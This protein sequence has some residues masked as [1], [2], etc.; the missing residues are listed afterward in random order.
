MQYK[1]YLITILFLLLGKNIFG[2]SPCKEVV[3]YY[4]NWQWYD[5]NYLVEPQSIDYSKYTII[6]YCFMSPE[7]DGS[8]TMTDAW[9][10]DNI[11]NGEKDW[12]NGGYIANT[13]LIEI[14]HNNGVKVLPSIGGWT[15]SNNFPV[16]AAD[17]VKRAIF[18]QACVDLIDSFNFDGIDIDWEYPGYTPHSGTPQDKVNFSLLLYDI[19]TAIDSFGLIH[20][21]TMLLTAAVGAAKER[22]MD[23]EW[24][25][26]S[27]YLDIINLMTYDFFG[28]Y[29]S[30]TNHNSPLYAPAHGDPGYNLDSAVI[31]LVNDFGVSP[32][33]ITVGLAFYGHSTITSGNPG[34]HVASTGT[35][36]NTTF[37]TDAGSPLYYNIL[38]QISLFTD[39]WDSQARVPYLTGN[40]GLNTFVSY[41]NENSIAEKAQYILDNNLRGAIIWEITGDYL[42][43]SSGSGVIK[44]T[45]LVDTLNAVFC[46][47]PV[48][49]SNKELKGTIS[50]FP[51]ITNGKVNIEL[52]EL[53]HNITVIVSNF[54][55]KT[56][57]TK[58]IYSAISFDIE[59]NGKAGLYI[60][61]V[62][63]S[64]YKPSVFKVLKTN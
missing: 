55:G 31:R 18:A 3:G 20:G 61:Q 17:P 2:Q 51:S 13:S 63:I 12:T 15:L 56:V 49:N 58:N 60:M 40:G 32:Q 9:A 35:V 8:I 48:S 52:P 45:P 43:T 37:S 4:P 39:N 57:S 11:L 28:A 36:D 62:N 34:L 6:N 38:E 23:I 64:G 19:R 7:P 54:Q 41:D 47:S 22:M 21:K 14:A 1:Y 50:T 42:E 10:D 26:V 59:I 5:R 44:N 30:L 25:I 29:S 46:S 33:K 24:P 53:C 16:I 27:Q